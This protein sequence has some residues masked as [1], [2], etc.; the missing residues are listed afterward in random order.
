MVIQ[1]TLP[2]D[3]SNQTSEIEEELKKL[4]VLELTP[5]DAINYLYE[6]KNKLK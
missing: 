5:M 6:L 2:L 1:T 3:F 4:N